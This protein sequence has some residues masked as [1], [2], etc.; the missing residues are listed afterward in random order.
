MASLEW[1]TPVATTTAIWT[2]N[3][4]NIAVG[5][6]KPKRREEMTLFK[7]YCVDR[8]KGVVTS[9]HTLV[10]N[11]KEDAAL[12]LQLAPEEKILKSTDDLDVVWQ[13]VGRFEKRV[14][15]RVKME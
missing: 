3:G 14:I 13:T 6:N 11:D 1:S 9:E 12:E 7:V 8:L 4:S 10:G 2:Y 15:E 5:Y